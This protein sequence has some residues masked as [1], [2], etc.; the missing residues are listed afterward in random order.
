M[1]VKGIFQSHK[2]ASESLRDFTC[3]NNGKVPVCTIVKESAI[4]KKDVTR[5]SKQIKLVLNWFFVLIQRKSFTKHI[6]NDTN[7]NKSMW[8]YRSYDIF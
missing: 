8:V 6:M 4:S 7:G 1:R 2:K 3:E 5:E